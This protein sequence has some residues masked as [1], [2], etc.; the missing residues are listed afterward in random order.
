M[1]RKFATWVKKILSQLFPDSHHLRYLASLP[2]LEKWRKS[3]SETYPV[4]ERRYGLYQ[5]LIEKIIGDVPIEYLEFGVY[6]GATIAYWV[7]K[8]TN[9]QSRF[10]GFDTFTGLPEKWE[11]LSNSME[12]G[13]FSTGGVVPDIKDT[14][15]S[16]VPGLFQDTL[17]K[18][19]K[20]NPITNRLVVH[21]DADI[22]SATLYT[23]T[24][25]HEL[26]KPG[27]IIVFDEF[28]SVLHE[29]RALEDYCSSYRVK[30]KVLG[31]TRSDRE[32]Y[33]RLA[34]EIL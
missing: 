22:Y 23:L 5:H 8:Q 24:R 16:F 26:L 7:E 13:H 3:H 28:S 19:L 17:P 9:P 11:F 33:V 6:K 12:Q 31:A 25:M 30:Y 1:K 18:F 10:F 4:F 2:L 29:F 15:V 20:E 32:Y 21:L 27:T 14:R 34:I